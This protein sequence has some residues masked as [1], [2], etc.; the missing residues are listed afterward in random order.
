MKPIF[1]RVA[2]TWISETSKA[3]EDVI[4]ITSASRTKLV[5]TWFQ[6]LLR[7]S[8]QRMAPAEAS[9]SMLEMARLDRAQ[10]CFAK[11]FQLNLRLGMC[12]GMS[13][14]V[15]QSIAFDD[16]DMVTWPVFQ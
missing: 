1:L 14:V 7:V 3:D 6:R 15:R 9:I 10:R 5:S 8:H 12:L 13:L 2:T 11:H 16:Q 4:E